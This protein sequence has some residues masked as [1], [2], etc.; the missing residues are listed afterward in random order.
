M[1]RSF[2]GGNYCEVA[3]NAV[4]DSNV[5]TISFWLNSTQ[6]TGNVCLF[7]R[8][9]SATRNGFFVLLNNTAGKL[10]LGAYAASTPAVGSLTSTLTVNDGVWRNFV[11]VFN[12]TTAANGNK[13]YVAGA[14][15]KQ[16]ASSQTWNPSGNPVRAGKTQDNFWAALT[17]KMADACWWDVE[18]TADE[19]AAIGKGCSPRRVRPGNLQLFLPLA[20]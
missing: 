5:F 15:D 3:S 1:A 14:L 20:A 2:S 12:R 19:I 9:N 13:L 7:S 8:C 11:G 18:L 4:F 10:D 6:T 16:S 17:G